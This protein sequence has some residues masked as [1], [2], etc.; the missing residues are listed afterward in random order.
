MDRGVGVTLL[1][2]QGFR[3][4][5]RVVVFVGLITLDPTSNVE[6]SLLRKKSLLSICIPLLATGPL[7][8]P[9]YSLFFLLSWHIFLDA[10]L[11]VSNGFLGETTKDN[12]EE[13]F[14]SPNIHEEYLSS[15]LSHVLF[16]F[17]YIELLWL[18]YH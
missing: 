14:P 11:R 10:H 5:A 15:L 4:V 2:M 17:I 8:L 12:D 3:D 6:H 18:N 7:S 1:G 9:L 13:P 16:L